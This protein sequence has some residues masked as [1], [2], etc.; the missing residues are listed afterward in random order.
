[1]KVRSSTNH[2]GE[3]TN[4]GLADEYVRHVLDNVPQD[5]LA[6][7]RLVSTPEFTYLASNLIVVDFYI[8]LP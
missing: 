2:R 7:F 5:Q 3:T 8:A 1:M 6:S 4:G